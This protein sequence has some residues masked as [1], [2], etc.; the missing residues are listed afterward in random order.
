MSPRACGQGELAELKEQGLEVLVQLLHQ[1]HRPKFDSWNPCEK[2]RHG[3]VKGRREMGR[4]KV[5][6]MAHKL[7]ST[8]AGG[9]L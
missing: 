9:Q 2:P 1:E 6:P 4:L 7:G 8:E 5:K 3:D